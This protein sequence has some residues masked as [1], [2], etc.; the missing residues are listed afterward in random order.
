M[1]MKPLYLYNTLTREKELFTP[2]TDKNVSMYH[3][4]PTVYWRQHI[5]NLRAVVM[6]DVLVRTLGYLGYEV[7][8]VRNYTDVGHLTSDE[9]AGED[10]MALGSKREGVSPLEIADKYIQLYDADTTA[11]GVQPPHTSPKATEHIEAMIA[12]VETL[13]EKGFAY[14][15]DSAVYFDISKAKDYTRLSNQV[16]ENNISGAGSGD[17]ADSEKRNP[18]DFAVWFFKAGAHANAIQTWKSPFTSPLVENGEGFPGWHIECSAMAKQY[19]GDTIDIHMGGIEH[20]PVHHTNEIAQSESANGAPFAKYWIHNEHLLVDNAKMSKS[21]GTS[22]SLADIVEK[23][24]EP[25]DLRYLFLG[26]NYRSKQ[27]FTWESVRAAKTAR[28]RIVY[29]LGTYPN[30]G[31]V[32]ID[33]KERFVNALADD[34]NTPQALAVISEVLGSDLSISDKKATIIDFDKVFGLGLDNIK[35]PTII[36]FEKDLD[37]VMISTVEEPP[38][39]VLDKIHIRL[40]A[41]KNKEWEVSDKLRD[42]IKK[43]GYDINDGDGVGLLEDIL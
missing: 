30:D 33:Y 14:T 4:G 16:L 15:T 35:K 19:L 39:A 11:L 17:V 18:A 36:R 34:L 3:C 23:G 42:E 32:N 38:K 13:L 20:V 6:A 27:N 41:R 12:M 31:V 26:A 1:G 43:L 9:D 8:L 22:Y 21:E 28:K 10:K 29:V 7:D 37:D 2:Q 5:G 24:Y 40:R 25:M